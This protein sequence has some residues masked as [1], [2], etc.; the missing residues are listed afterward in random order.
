MATPTTERKLAVVHPAPSDA[1]RF[2]A[3]A[4]EPLVAPLLAGISSSQ[5]AEI[6]RR[7]LI[8][9]ARAGEGTTTIA[10]GTAIALARD[11]G[12]R[13]LLVETNL[14]RPTLARSLGMAERP[15][16]GEVVH[17]EATEAE[18]VRAIETIPGLLVLP[19]G[20]P[21]SPTAAELMSQKGIELVDASR[22]NVDHVVLDVP[23]LL[24]GAEGSLLLRRGDFVALV[25]RDGLTPR[26]DVERA[27]GVVTQAG[28]RVAG[29]VL[30]RCDRRHLR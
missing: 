24:G 22:L 30:N 16:L 6:P 1:T 8:T 18:A 11:L 21:R 12:R 14:A 2:R 25:V 5:G 26:A 19:A 9:A 15:G 13:V 4:L 3:D 23:P 20:A 7:I 17:G 27:I 29:I 10:A 28:A